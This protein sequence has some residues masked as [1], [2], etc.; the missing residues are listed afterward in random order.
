MCIR[1]SVYPFWALFA[2][3]AMFCLVGLTNALGIY[4]STVCS[5]ICTVGGIAAITALVCGLPSPENRAG[6]FTIYLLVQYSGFAVGPAIAGYAL[7]LWKF[8]PVFAGYGVIALVFFVLARRMLS[9]LSD[10]PR[11]YS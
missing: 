4:V 7:D 5:T 3:A 11:S 6:H 10:D 1:D 9:A 8:T 2:A